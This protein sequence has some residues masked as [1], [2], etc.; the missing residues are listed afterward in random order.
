MAFSPLRVA[1]LVIGGLL[2]GAALL[3]LGARCYGPAAAAGFWGALIVFGV[4][5][6]RW[7]YKPLTEQAPTGPGWSATSERFVDPESG[8]LVTVYF[9]AA[10]GERRYIG[11]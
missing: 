10:T 5:F 8:K 4:L 3:L 7:R 6:E 9:H 1:L 11:H 2:L